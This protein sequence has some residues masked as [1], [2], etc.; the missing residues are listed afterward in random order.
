[1]GWAGHQ[2]FRLQATITFPRSDALQQQEMIVRHD[3]RASAQN[4]I[5]GLGLLD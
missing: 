4:G 1:M 2:D 5:V 3:Q